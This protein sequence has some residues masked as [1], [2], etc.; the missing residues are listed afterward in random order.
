MFQL[1]RYDP[2]PKV[3]CL[4]CDAKL[5]QHHR[6]IQRVIQNQKKIQGERPGLGERPVI[7]R[8]KCASGRN[9]IKSFFLL[10]SRCLSNICESVYRR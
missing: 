7:V 3:I 10:S 6:F 1:T 4:P 2:L 5:E 9:Q 8:K